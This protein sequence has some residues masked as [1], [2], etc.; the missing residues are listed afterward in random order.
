LD[1]AVEAVKEAAALWIDGALDSGEPI[2]APSDLQTLSQNP[3]FAGW[4]VGIV[5]LDPALFDDT[6]E[7]VNITIPKRI[8]N[9][10]DA[11]ATA[12][13][14]SRG[15]FISDLTLRFTHTGG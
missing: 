5:E 7:R 8:L 6:I 14:Q 9:R 2:P 3:E 11:L 1:E 10:L 13:G 12:R 4:I 15:A